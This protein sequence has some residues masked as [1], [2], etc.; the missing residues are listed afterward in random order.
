MLAKKTRCGVKY[1][2]WTLAPKGARFAVYFWEHV[3]Y[4]TKKSAAENTMGRLS[5]YEAEDAQIINL[6][7]KDNPVVKERPEVGKRVKVQIGE[8]SPVYEGP[9]TTH[10]VDP[11]VFWVRV[12]KVDG[13]PK[14][15][16]SYRTPIACHINGL[17]GG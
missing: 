3:I 11:V 7:K 1:A 13:K 2:L 16:G 8:C 17:I 4:H 10:D 5:Y 6:S 12:E 14:R 15:Q 9:V